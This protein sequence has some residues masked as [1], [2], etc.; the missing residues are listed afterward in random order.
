[1]SI[2]QRS[3]R[4]RCSPAYSSLYMAWDSFVTTVSGSRVLIVYGPTTAKSMPVMN[5]VE[6][7]SRRTHG[8]RTAEYLFSGPCSRDA[9]QTFYFDDSVPQV[10]LMACRLGNM[11]GIENK[12]TLATPKSPVKPYVPGNINAVAPTPPLVEDYPSAESRN[13]PLKVLP[14]VNAVHAA[15]H[16]N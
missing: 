6:H 14:P 1:M 2:T 16:N 8:L 3:L 9:V 13:W 11:T 10:L 5:N 12:G 15:I 7:S 4:V